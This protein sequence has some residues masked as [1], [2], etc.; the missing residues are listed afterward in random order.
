MNVCTNMCR[1]SKIRRKCVYKTKQNSGNK[2][3]TLT[4]KTVIVM[5]FEK[6]ISWE[7]IE[8]FIT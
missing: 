7:N 4:L 3:E 8:T 5:L 2:N 1:N 6:N